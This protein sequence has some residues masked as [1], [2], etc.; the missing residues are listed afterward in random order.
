MGS[1]CPRSTHHI[2][3]LVCQQSEPHSRSPVRYRRTPQSLPRWTY[4]AV[5]AVYR[6]HHQSSPA[7][8]CTGSDCAGRPNPGGKDF[9]TTAPVQR[10]SS[11]APARAHPPA[12]SP[13]ADRPAGCSI[14][15]RPSSCS[16]VRGRS[17]TVSACT[18]PGTSAARRRCTARCCADTDG[19]AAGADSSSSCPRCRRSIPHRHSNRCSPGA[20]TGRMGSTGVAA[21]RRSTVRSAGGTPGA[22]VHPVHRR[23]HS[24]AA[25]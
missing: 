20:G 23:T 18:R 21:G 1:H 4:R 17:S 12:A 10:G 11:R 14:R 25:G 22:I 24:R 19:A 8:C 9:R 3:A 6:E 15:D 2:P 16:S 5:E 13:R 7:D